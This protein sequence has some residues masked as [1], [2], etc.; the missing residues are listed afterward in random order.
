MPA[1]LVAGLLDADYLVSKLVFCILIGWI[2]VRPSA[3]K[4]ERLFTF[5]QIPTVQSRH[6]LHSQSLESE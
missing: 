1:C 5:C 4:L 6:R 3:D 2:P